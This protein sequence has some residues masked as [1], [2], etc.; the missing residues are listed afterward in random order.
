MKLIV[1]CDE[2]WGI[3]NKGELLY[4]YKEDMMFFK[5]KTYWDVVV[6]GKNTFLS[7]PK[8]EPLKD[9]YNIV[10]TTD[11]DF[12]K[13]NTITVHSIPELFK[14]LDG[15]IKETSY[16]NDDIWIIGGGSI[17]EQ[18]LPYCD[19]AYV[20]MVTEKAKECD[21]FFPNLDKSPDWKWKRLQLSKNEPLKFYEYQNINVKD[22]REEVKERE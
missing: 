14:L 10:L 8:Q 21:C 22:W 17:Y 19:Y 6:M 1:C 20:T 18:L 12:K 2:N 13:Q 3:G 4:H 11:K 7:L 16:T 5:N 15:M 9:R